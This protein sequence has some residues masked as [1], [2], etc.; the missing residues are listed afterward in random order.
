MEIILEV[1]IEVRDFQRNVPE[2]LGCFAGELGG[3]FAGRSTVLGENSRS[4]TD[5]PLKISAGRR[6]MAAGSLLCWEDPPGLVR[7]GQSAE[8][9][10]SR[11]PQRAVR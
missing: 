7:E 9:A 5:L 3:K 8:A 2:L 11:A 6:W 10:A 4:T 1:A